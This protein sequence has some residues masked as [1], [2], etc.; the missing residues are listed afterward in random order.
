LFDA[1]FS[2]NQMK[3]KKLRSVLLIVVLLFSG[4]T[5]WGQTKTWDRGANT[6]NW[7]DA[8][9][10][11]PNGVPNAAND[12]VININA[13]ILV[14]TNPII[15]SLTIS[16]N[17]TVSFTSSGA[18]RTIT[19]DNTGSSIATGSTL[20]LQGSTGGGIR[21]MTLAFS[22]SGQTMNIAGNLILTEVGEGTIYNS[23]NSI[24]T[25]TGTITNSSTGTGTTGVIISD[26]ANLSFAS[27]GTCVH[28]VNGNAIPTA[29][30]DA[31]STCNVTGITNTNVTGL[32]Q[33]FGNFTWNCAGQG[34]NNIISTAGNMV[35]NGDFRLTSGIFA[36]SASTT[37]QRSLTISGDYIQ[38]GGTFD[39]NRAGNGTLS[40]LY[41][42][43]DFTNSAANE[44]ITTVG[45]GAVNGNIVFNGSSQQTLTFTNANAPVWT[46]F[47]VNAGSSLTLGSNVTLTGYGS[48][49]KYYADFIVNGTVDFG[50]YILNDIPYNS[51]TNASHFIL[52]S[53]AELITANAGGIAVTGATGSVQ[54]SSTRTY[55]TGA[56]Y[57]YNG[58]TAQ[59]TGNGLTGANDLT[60]DN[61]SGVTLSA[62]TSV[63]NSLLFVDGILSTGV[64]SLTV[65]NSS[66]ASI[67][68]ATTTRF[69]NGVLNWNLVQGSSYSF[70]VG[71][72]TTFLPFGLEVTSGSAP[73]VSVEAYTGN[74]GGT[75][76]N[77]LSS[78]STT[79]FWFASVLSGSYTDGSVS[80]T[81][82][83]ALGSL[84]A[85]GRS[86]S[87][88][89]NYSTLNGSVS[90]TS[91]NSSD[92]T[93]NSLGY[94]AMAIK[95][96]ITTGIITPNSFC[97][98][99]SV[100][101][102]YTITGT[103]IAGNIFT[104]QLSNAA[105]SF[106][107]PTNIGS[108]T[109][110]TS[111]TITATIPLTQ[112]TG[113]GYRIRVISGNPAITGTN[114]TSNLTITALPTAII[115]ND[116]GP[117]CAGDDA[118]FT[119]TGTSGATVSYKVN[120]GSN[121]TVTLTGVTATITISNAP[122]DQT[123]TLVSVTD[124]TCS[125]IL[126]A[127]ATITVNPLPEIGNFINN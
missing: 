21:S 19:I 14:N 41:I 7:G 30:W 127:N 124:G 72:G 61:G 75:A 87:L 77:P 111:G 90:G 117:L 78:L 49:T 82:P 11:N 10:W 42:A 89:G 38:T 15:N 9:N 66:P 28:G 113:N 118:I 35:V 100:N 59:V 57:V 46:S 45:A 73:Q 106:T 13:T 70:P 23:S 81:R 122:D 126:S 12:V 94:F 104:A 47:I 95:R 99:A 51:G 62:N 71:K 17:A 83:A 56:D 24:T 54:V 37:E 1:A 27:G 80:L 86:I 48:E 67:S 91:I 2:L 116:N 114:N 31:N 125:Q 121:Q 36:L 44:S 63:S 69:V 92:P 29:T 97:Q 6:N 123:L 5:G 39:F 105:G 85:I 119:L 76:I 40:T 93:A 18:G 4:L 98:G 64:N 120:S 52:N 25:V 84:N 96:T 102:P 88:A 101:V 22:G 33:T 110:T 20:T 74:A 16:N 79:E 107:S 8:D 34:T 3:L 26:A 58:N 65:T 115:S 53:G 55:N 50:N 109:S 108:L 60:I 112:A 32:N 43:G 103:F 68:G